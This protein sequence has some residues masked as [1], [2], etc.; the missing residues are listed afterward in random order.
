MKLDWKGQQI[1][2]RQIATSES[3]PL[4][5]EGEKSQ[6]VIMDTFNVSQSVAAGVLTQLLAEGLIEESGRR[7]G[8]FRITFAG[9][10]RLGVE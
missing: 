10:E 2:H 6:R 7:P 1:K 3:L 8:Y 9:Q 4:F 5:R